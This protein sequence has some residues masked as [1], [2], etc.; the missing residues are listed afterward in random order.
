GNEGKS[1]LGSLASGLHQMV[2]GEWGG[3]CHVAVGEPID[4]AEGI[5]HTVGILRETIQ[6]GRKFHVGMQV[7]LPWL[8]HLERLLIGMPESA[9]S[10]F[11]EEMVGRPD[12]FGDQET[13]STLAAVFL[14]V[15]HVSDQA[16]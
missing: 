1:V 10:R 3:E 5:V 8:V 15:C 11:V 12:L 14:L 7:H 9:R 13:L 16:K 6:L 2:S 4:P